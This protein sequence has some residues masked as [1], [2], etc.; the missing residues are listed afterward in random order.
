VDIASLPATVQQFL[1][2]SDETEKQRY[3]QG[4]ADFEAPFFNF[5]KLQTG[6]KADFIK[7]TILQKAVLR[8]ETIILPDNDFNMDMQKLGIYLLQRHQIKKL[9]YSLGLRMEQFSSEALQQSNQS[10]FTQDYLRFFPS[11][12]FNYLLPD[13]SHTIGFN[14][15]RR[16]NRPGFFDLNPFISY[17][18]PLNLETGNPALRPEIANLYELT[19]HKEMNKL[20]FDLT[21][22]RRK[23]RDVIQ[24]YITALGNDQT[25]SSSIN[26][27]EQTHQGLEGQLEYRLNKVIRTTATFVFS[28]VAYRDLAYEINFEKAT[29]WN[30]RLKQQFILPHQ[31]KIE[32]TATYR[33]PRY[34]AQKKSHEQFYMDFVV[35]KK[36]NNK[37]GSISIGIR[38]IFNT[39]EY[40][41]SLYTPNFEVKKNYKWQTRQITLGLRYNIFNG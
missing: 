37:K 27:G 29:S 35:N 31:W 21:L 30:T 38:D 15:T 34:Q 12:Q 8:S 26:I 7:Y 2:S 40:I 14:Y 19:Y 22:Y 10:T 20:S 41:Y 3:F 25:L 13:N 16:I 33:A 11:I 28:E 1:L 39:R 36:I 17:E 5:G 6:I 32:W 23:T 18:D 24:E 9:D 4:K